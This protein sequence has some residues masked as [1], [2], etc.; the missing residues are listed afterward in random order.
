MAFSGGGT[1]AAAL[2]ES[3]LREMRAT[4]YIA[5]DGQRHALTDDIR[6][7]SSVSG[8]SV[9]AAWFGLRGADGLDD[10]RSRFLTRDNMA[11]LGLDAINPVTWLSLVFTSYTRSK[12]IE[13]MFD[14]Q[15][16]DHATMAELNRPNRPFILPSATDMAGGEAFTFTPQRFDDICSNFDALRISTAVAASAA[17]PIVLSPV[18]LRN[19]TGH[20]QGSVEPAKW[21]TIALT[22]PYSQYLNLVGYRAARYTNDLRHGDQPFRDIL[23]LHLLDGGLADNLAVKP[24]RSALISAADSVGGL[25]AINRGQIRKLVVIVV[26]ARSDPPNKVY[27]QA[28]TPGLLA[29]TN[30]VASWPMDAN[31]TSSQLGLESLLTEINQAVEGAKQMNPG[32]GGMKVYGVTVDYDQIPTDSPDHLALRDEAKVVP[33]SWSLT[34]AQLD[35]TERAGRLLLDRHPCFGRLIADLDA[36]P[37]PGSEGAVHLACATSSAN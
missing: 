35:V 18:D 4:T 26:N 30:A 23:Y 12:I 34:P 28:S 31:T 14:D 10:L 8:G 24:L 36:T 7:I 15:L 29:S 9:T 37:A 21:A 16:F 27:Q 19:N 25:N 3:V 13:D 33:T 22:N 32:F 5:A 2:A 1:R 17:V 11:A 20:C 6:A